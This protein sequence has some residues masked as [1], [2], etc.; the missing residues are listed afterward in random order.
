MCLARVSHLYFLI[1]AWFQYLAPLLFGFRIYKV[2]SGQSITI[3]KLWETIMKITQSDMMPDCKP[4]RM[5]DIDKSVADISLIEK[6]LGF[7]SST[8]FE[9]NLLKTY[10]WILISSKSPKG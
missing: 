8:C 7:S 6:E 3:N 10:E 9:E 2:A 4:E 1:Q 5:G